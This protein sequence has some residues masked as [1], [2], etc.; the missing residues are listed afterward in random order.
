ME[1]NYEIRNL[2]CAHC[3][4]KIE[5]AIK[6]LDGV[7]D[8][9]LNF[10]MRKMKIKGELT[11]ELLAE[12]NRIAGKIEAGVSIVPLNAGSHHHEHEHHSHGE[13]C[14]CGHEHHHEHE[15]HSHGEDC[16]CG[17][18]HHHEHEHERRSETAAHEPQHAHESGI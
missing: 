6:K 1:K 3:G 8:A 9:V 15:H 4:G 12:I 5:E 13:D 7:E 10:P 2:G 17:H 14:C 16:C 11:D 18:E